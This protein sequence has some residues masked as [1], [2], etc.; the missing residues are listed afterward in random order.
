[1]EGGLEKHTV[2]EG[3]TGARESKGGHRGDDK[4]TNLDPG[5]LGRRLLSTVSDEADV[6][7]DVKVVEARLDGELSK[8][9][10]HGAVSQLQLD[11]RCCR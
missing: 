6:V 10:D 8:N 9:S 4:Q 5:S 2:G 7:V 1:M 3:G 11:G